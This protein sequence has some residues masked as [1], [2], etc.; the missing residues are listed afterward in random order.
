MAYVEY[1]RAAEIVVEVLPR[2]RSWPDLQ[3]D[4][5]GGTLPKYRL[6]Q[7]KVNNQTEQFSKIK[8]IIQNNNLRSGVQ[9]TSGIN[10][11][12]TGSMAPPQL[13]GHVVN[14]GPAA[15]KVKPAPS[16][17]PEN[18]H[19]KT[20]TLEDRLAALR[21]QEGGID[22]SRPGSR[23]STH[24]SMHS[25][26]TSMPNASDY[27]SRTSTD[28]LS[29]RLAQMTVGSGARPQGPRGMPNGS[30]GPP[31]PG[32]LP[33]NTAITSMPQEPKATYSPARNMQAPGNIELPRQTPRSLVSTSSRR[34][35]M[36]AGSSASSHAPHRTYSGSENG[37][38]F[39]PLSR[40]TSH[41]SGIQ[42][43]QMPR[44]KSSSASETSISSQ[45]LY[46][47]LERFNILLIDFR[48]RQEFDLGHIFHRSIICV[49]PIHVTEGMSADEL[50]ERMVISPEVE[51]EMFANRDK[52]DLI[53]Y[54][55][56]GTVSEA[57]LTR[58][59]DDSQVK[60]RS[61]HQALFDFNQDKPLRRPP[62]LL[63]GGIEEW[64]D[65]VGPQAL[66]TS[67]TAS[68][69][70]QG[71][72]LQRRP[73]GGPLQQPKRRYREYNPLDDDEVRKWR[74]RARAESVVLMPPPSVPEEDED[75]AQAEGVDADEE[76]SYSAI[77]DF[78]Q[79]FPDAGQIDTFAFGPLQP[80]RA[81][82]EPPPKVPLAS[83]PSA[84]APPSSY[85]S[86]PTRPQPA[87]PRQSYTGVSDRAGSQNVPAARSSSLVPY[88][89]AK[90]LS[91]SF[92]IPS[93]GLHNFRF[94]CYMN[95]TLQALSATKPLSIYF[96]EEGWR[97]HLQSETWKGSRG[98]MPEAY[99]NVIRSLWKNDVSYIKPTTF[100]AFCGKLNRI[101]NTDDQEQDAK[102]FC[103]FLL[104]LLHEDLNV[105]WTQGP[106]AA[107]TLEQEIRREQM[108]KHVVA[109]I[110]WDKHL[111]RNSSFTE[112]LFGFQTSSQLRFLQCGHTSTTHE[113]ERSLSVEIPY[114]NGRYPTLD[115][116]LSSYCKEEALDREE[117]AKCDQCNERRDSTKRITITR[118]PQ[119]LVIHFKRF[120]SS[121][122]G[123]R[124]IATP[125][126]FPLDNFDLAPY[127]LPPPSPAEAEKI[128]SN[129]GSDFLRP[130]AGVTPPHTYSA[131]AVVRHH[132][133]SIATGHYTAL[134]RDIGRTT[135]RC[136]ND[137]S[138]NDL[139]VGG[140][141][142]SGSQA[143]TSGEAYIVF[144]QRDDQGMA[145]KAAAPIG[146][147]GVGK[148]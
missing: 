107:L 129:Y 20:L 63:I 53:I 103:D 8:E 145:G 38:Y 81:P 112:S 69:T 71:R 92:K 119:I 91:T 25:S 23:G 97:K 17:K 80:K 60:L 146:P 29:G 32:K 90:Y 105:R 124:K 106:F 51:Q 44:R 131:Y 99:A 3:M 18:M 136:F 123:Q 101:W 62:I 24:S 34:T 126:N 2:H 83:Y 21:R 58:P 19:G 135:W 66:A 104:D 115:D 31:V 5:G 147:G 120:G 116:C 78:N 16:P 133:E 121:T 118:A 40:P 141:G 36:A 142:L 30:V 28:S 148:I 45:R 27:G 39:P 93:T 22:T 134:V 111:K 102:E 85:P 140:P 98:V 100:R 125:I 7:K 68:R 139:Q 65:L 132:G 61:L 84:P 88:I 47:F 143:L 37:E 110:E 75:S 89:P 56:N 67:D 130:E 59:M 73:I 96:M 64:S 54:Y 87:A 113:F 35:S 26:P 77:D 13:N 74:E 41:A 109:R 127:M 49:D 144:Y 95:A 108:P 79:R 43:G 57:F 14:G 10:M 12:T 42:P 55:D 46:D 138:H 114:L 86:I 9:R 94:T 33:L 48:P 128:V 76:L 11:A 122:R 117:R 52:Y 6:L 4:H 72:P 82:P 50:L 15:P 137:R 1:L 70:K